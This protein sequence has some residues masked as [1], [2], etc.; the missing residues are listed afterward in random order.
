[1]RFLTDL[2]HRPNPAVVG[3]AAFDA[4]EREGARVFRDR[5]E[6]CHAARLSA[7][8]PASRLPF[9]QWEPMLLDERAP[10]VWG[11]I[12]YRKTGVTPY[13]HPDGA[14]TP[15]LRRLYKKHPYFTNGSAKSI[16]DVL[17]G[18]RSTGETTWHAEAPATAAPL[19]EASRRA[20]RAF[21][22]LL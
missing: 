6:A 8:E 7:D 9:E 2:S 14:R 18:V 20:L 13:V 15:S 22:E 19:D 11:S 17:A 16:D 1:M 10:I 3:R 21:L 5:C 12:G 4:T